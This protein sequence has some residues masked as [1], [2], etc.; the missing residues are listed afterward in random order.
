MDE[1]A[2]AESALSTHNPYAMPAAPV[3]LPPPV[4]AF[5]PLRPASR[6]LRLGARLVDQFVYLLCAV[7]LFGALVVGRDAAGIAFAIGIGLTFV[8]MAALLVV[9]LVGLD[10]RG[11]TLGKRALGIRILRRDGTHPSFGR[12]FGL[13]A[14]VPGVIGA[15]PLIGPLFALIDVLWI[16]GDERRCLHD[17]MADTVVVPA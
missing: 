6:W 13:R 5:A 1:H 3:A 10:R 7:P 14:V 15:V 8:A 9:N 17:L 4:P 11:Q 16:L 12:S 2:A